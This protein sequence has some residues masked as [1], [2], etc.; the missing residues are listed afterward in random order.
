LYAVDSKVEPDN[1]NAILFQNSIHTT[2]WL[3]V[4]GSIL[5]HA[6]YALLFESKKLKTNI[7]CSHAEIVLFNCTRFHLKNYGI[8]NWWFGCGVL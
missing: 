4:L 2:T 7:F 5:V 6:L 3:T 1:V 8:W